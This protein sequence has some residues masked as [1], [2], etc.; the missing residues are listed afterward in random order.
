MFNEFRSF[1]S[2]RIGAAEIA[3]RNSERYKQQEKFYEAA[4]AR[5][6]MRL[7]KDFFKTFDPVDRAATYMT[8]IIFEEVYLQGIRD[9]LALQSFF[10]TTDKSLS[11]LL[12]EMATQKELEATPTEDSL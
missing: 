9:T 7:G 4:M 5:L 10:A 2:E 3:A 12:E 8:C 6:R 1:V 11:Q